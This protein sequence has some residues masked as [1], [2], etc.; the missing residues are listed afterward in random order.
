M[1]PEKIIFFK[2]EVLFKAVYLFQG[3]VE[4][5]FDCRFHP[6]DADLL[7]TASFDGTIKLWN[8]NTLT[9]VSIGSLLIYSLQPVLMVLS[10][11]GI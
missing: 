4:T 11:Y 3:H 7:A 2:K 1:N 9:C 10:N 8:I 6:A 5:I